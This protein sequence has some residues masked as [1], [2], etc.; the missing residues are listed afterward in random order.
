[1]KKIEI[2]AP[3]GSMESVIAAANAGADAVYFGMKA[4]SARASATNFDPEETKSAITYLKQRG[5][6]AYV[7]LNTLF[8]DKEKG[9]LFQCAQEAAHAG[10]DAF[11]VQDLGLFSMLK[12][13]FPWVDLHASTQMAVHSVGGAKQLEAMGFSRVVLGREL[14][15]SEMQD[16]AQQ[17]NIELEVFVHGALC[18]SLS[19]N[20]YASSFIGTRSGNRGRCAQTCRLPFTLGESKKDDYMLSLKDLSYIEQAEELAKIGIYSLKIEG[21]MKRPEYV[22]A[23]SNALYSELHHLPYEKGQVHQVFSRSG[24]TKSYFDGELADMFGVRTKKDVMASKEPM[25]AIAAQFRHE[26][27]RFGVDFALTMQGEAGEFAA[28]CGDME[29]RTQ[30]QA[31]LA[32]TKALD[33]AQVEKSFQKTG[34]T[35]FFCQNI[36]FE[37]D[38]TSFLPAAALN[39]LRRTALEH[40]ANTMGEIPQRETGQV[41]P[42]LAP[43]LGAAD[44]AR[45]Y[46]L[47]F[48]TAG[49]IDFEKI[50]TLKGVADIVLP[51]EECLRHEKALAPHKGRITV[52]LPY[53]LFTWE[54]QV[55]E[56]LMQAKALGYTRVEAGNIAHLWMAKQAGLAFTVGM[57]MNTLNSHAVDMLANLGAKAIT[58]SPEVSIQASRQLQSSVP[59]GVLAYGCPP[60]MTNRV[61]PIKARIGC[62]ACGK[63][64]VLTDRLGNEFF[65]SCN[66]EAFYLHNP[67]PVYLPDRG[68]ELAHFDFLQLYF[69]KESAAEIAAVLDEYENCTASRPKGSYT[70]G[71]L[72]RE[73]L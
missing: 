12:Q 59:L 58:L 71:L 5:M 8:F 14:S 47:R 62:A 53:T 19:G 44:K 68:G 43:R 3:A 50:G 72:Y 42:L 38:G 33:F 48:A 32:K 29:Y 70:R 23:V 57:R 35:Q 52:E 61:C 20:C 41:L 7:T 64:Q 25:K 66:Q 10:V 69:T 73:I 24:F 2:L 56:Q 17:T 65:T 54:K 31:S 60:V 30:V 4:F 26:K 16:I 27:A 11:I 34:N 39:E 40:F 21:R 49:Q 45:A 55:Q 9:A 67:H 22:A 63:K 46:S 13:A 1:M 15:K 18:V 51:L 28:R 36:R 6:K 37:S